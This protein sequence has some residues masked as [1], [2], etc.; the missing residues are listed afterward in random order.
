MRRTQLYLDDEL[1]GTLRIRSQQAR[2]S[3]SDLV[4][5][6]VREKYSIGLAGRQQAM[7]AFAGIWTDR[8]DLSDP[9]LYL[10]GLRKGSRLKRVR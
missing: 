1:W 5:Q 10:R 3:I 9:D 2:T 4:R 8:N 6:A 7:R